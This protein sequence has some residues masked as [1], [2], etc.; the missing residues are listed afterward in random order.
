MPKYRINP[1]FMPN[2]AF[3]SIIV[4]RKPFKTQI[5]QPG[6]P[7]PRPFPL[8]PTWADSGALAKAKKSPGILPRLSWLQSWKA[9][10]GLIYRRVTYAVAMPN[11]C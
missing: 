9:T 6:A 4:S 2:D 5:S 11:H 7:V 8:A 10:R 1:V 3:F